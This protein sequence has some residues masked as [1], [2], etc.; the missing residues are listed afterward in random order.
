M[1]RFLGTRTILVSATIPYELRAVR[2]IQPSEETE[3]SYLD[4]TKQQLSFKRWVSLDQGAFRKGKTLVMANTRRKAANILNTIV[5]CSRCRHKKVAH[6]KNNASEEVSRCLVGNCICKGYLPDTLYLS[7][8][9]RKRDKVRILSQIYEK[10]RPKEQYMLVSRQVVEAGVII[11]FSHIFRE[12]APLDS[13]IQVMG[14]LNL[15]SQ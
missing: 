13:I 8:G 10:E 11:S 7:S 3:K 2:T 14:R 9:I 6:D 1:H 15:S 5:R 12:K 4:L